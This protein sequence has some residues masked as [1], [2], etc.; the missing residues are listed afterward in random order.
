MTGI[1]ENPQDLSLFTHT[2]KDVLSTATGVLFRLSLINPLRSQRGYLF[3]Y[4]EYQ[5]SF[6]HEVADRYYSI[7]AKG[8]NGNY[9]VELFMQK[10]TITES[11]LKTFT[12]IF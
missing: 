9:E 12:V 5:L 8:K 2:F 1:V 7:F 11:I 6:P 4:L 3:P 10:P